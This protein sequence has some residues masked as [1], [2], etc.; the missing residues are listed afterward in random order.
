V[1]G[2]S[3]VKGSWDMSSLIMPPEYLSCERPKVLF[4]SDLGRQEQT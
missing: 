3:P 2:D 1:S 4:L